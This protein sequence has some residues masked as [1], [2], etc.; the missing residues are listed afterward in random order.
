MM[1]A[2]RWLRTLPVLPVRDMEMAI[3]WYE[4]ALQLRTVYRH[5]GDLPTEPTNYAILTRDGLHIHLILDESPSQ[6]DNAHA[7]GLEAPAWTTAG[8][9]YLYLLVQDIDECHL[10]VQSR[11]IE[12][13]RELQTEIWGARAFNLVD[14]SGNVIHIEQA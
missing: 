1:M 9:G 2:G 6:N 13:S 11:K 10:E 8:T 4:Q 14:P 7:D 5:A 3:A 12:I